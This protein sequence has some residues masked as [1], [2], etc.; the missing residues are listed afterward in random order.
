M[1]W[2]PPCCAPKL[3][4]LGAW[5]VHYSTDYVFDGSGDQPWAKTDATGPLSVYGRPSSKASR[6]WPAAPAPDFAHQLGVCR[7]G[8]QLCQDHAASGLGARALTV[9]DDQ[10]GAPTSAELLADVTAHALRPALQTRSWRACTTAWPVVKPPGTAMPALCWA[11]PKPA[12]PNAQGRARASG[13]HSHQQLPHTRA[14]PP[15]FAAGHHQAANRVWADTATGS[16]RRGA[17]ADRNL[18]K[19]KHH[20][21]QLQPT[22]ACCAK[23]SSWPAARAPAC[24]RPRRW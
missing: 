4:A 14:A 10:F 6:P 3:Q 21:H 16:N 19:T 15:Q 17:H 5:L 18:R 22:A 13:T 1:L 9:I 7:R 20:D 12:G 11:K 2:R 8:R 23:A 24:T